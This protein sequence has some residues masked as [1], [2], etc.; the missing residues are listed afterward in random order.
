MYVSHVLYPVRVLGP[1]DRIGIWFS[2]CEHHCPGCSNP[3]LWD[4]QPQQEIAG[5][6]LLD[7]IRAVASAHPVSGFTLTGGDPFLQ[8][9]ALRELLPA[10]REIADDILVYTGYDYAGLV[11]QYPDLVSQIPVVIDGPYIEERNTNCPLRGSDNQNLIYR[12]AE[13]EARYTAYLSRYEN[14]IQNFSV[15]GGIVSVGIHRPG[16]KRQLK[17]ILEKRGIE[18]DE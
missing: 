16:Y 18:T 17:Q 12:D 8:P 9:E 2:G 13:T 11:R 3:E 15:R 7:M 5:G 4:P 14:R 10:L 1:G 6:K